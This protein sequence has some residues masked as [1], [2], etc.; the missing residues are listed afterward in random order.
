M[1][2]PIFSSSIIYAPYIYIYN[3]YIYTIYIYNIFI[4]TQYIYIYTIYIY[5][6][7]YN[8]YIYTIYTYIQYIHIYNIYIYIYIYIYIQYIHIYNIYI[9]TIYTYIQYIYTIYIYT[10]Y[11]SMKKMFILMKETIQLLQYPHDYGSFP[12][13]FTVNSALFAAHQFEE[14]SRSRGF[15]QK[16]EE[17]HH[18]LVL[19]GKN[20]GISMESYKLM[21][22]NGI[23]HIFDVSI[24]AYIY[25]YTVPPPKK[26]TMF[27]RSQRFWDKLPCSV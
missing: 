11:M 21:V 12:L 10:I 26:K 15:R 18:L 2:L 1:G 9:Y 6:Y 23:S 7:I 4:Y 5:I 24:S 27:L 19:N 3:I 8:I 16:A 13:F 17:H 14:I 20:H 25:I 22:F